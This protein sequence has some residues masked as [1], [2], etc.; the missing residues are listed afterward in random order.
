MIK[1]EYLDLLN[2]LVCNV[3]TLCFIYKIIFKIIENTL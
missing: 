3:N 1:Y 2:L